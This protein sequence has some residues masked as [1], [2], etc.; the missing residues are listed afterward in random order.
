MVVCGGFFP[1]PDHGA[2]FIQR[3]PENSV[4][5]VSPD[6]QATASVGGRH[7]ATG[8]TKTA[9]EDS[10]DTHTQACTCCCSRRGCN[11]HNWSAYGCFACRTR[12]PVG[13]AAAARSVTAAHR[14][15]AGNSHAAIIPT[16]F[17]FHRPSTCQPE[18]Q[19]AMALGY[20]YRC[21]TFP[22]AHRNYACR[23]CIHSPRLRCTAAEI[24]SRFVQ[25]GLSIADSSV[26]R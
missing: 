21:R 1:G 12:Q 4:P 14:R 16:A 22:T 3:F 2:R 8:R 24:R 15:F 25:S 13:R 23:Q 19:L 7:F 10:T 6:R 20:R 11:D 9:G 17:S 26:Q 18:R 5:S